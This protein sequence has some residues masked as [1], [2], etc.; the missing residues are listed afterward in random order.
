MS[1]E[2]VC[3]ALEVVDAIHT[4]GIQP[5]ATIVM[6][7]GKEVAAVA[8]SPAVDRVYEALRG[9]FGLIAE[10]TNTLAAAGVEITTQAAVAQQRYGEIAGADAQ[11]ARIS[12][13]LIQV[14]INIHK[15]ADPVHK[16]ME[17]VEAAIGQVLREGLD[18]IAQL[19]G[20]AALGAQE[21]HAISDAA[22]Q[23]SQLY[24]GRITQGS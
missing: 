3:E 22:V 5:A 6:E 8:H 1:I 18:R 19:G 2:S 20:Q 11:P 14:G 7:A 12:G 16:E 13:A 4:Q 10:Q 21:V 17:Q 24:V 23:A 15:A 9:L